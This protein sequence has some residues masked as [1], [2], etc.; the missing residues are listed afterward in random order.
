MMVD[1]PDMFEESSPTQK[2]EDILDEL[3][4]KGLE[5]IAA[6]P[7]SGSKEEQEAHETAIEEVPLQAEV[8]RRVHVLK[9][10]TMRVYMRCM[11]RAKTLVRHIYPLLQQ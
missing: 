7:K 6:P 10:C 11:Q 9:L 8:T 3:K 5:S 4:L 2:M 1:N